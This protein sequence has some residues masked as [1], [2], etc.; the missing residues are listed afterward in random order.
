MAMESQRDAA[1]RPGAGTVQASTLGDVRKAVQ[2]ASRA[3]HHRR[4]VAYAL[5]VHSRTG[6]PALLLPRVR[7]LVRQ[8]LH[9]VYVLNGRLKLERAG[10]VMQVTEEVRDALRS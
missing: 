3:A 6:I 9:Q 2:G 5:G 8:A 4:H 1:S 10:H 7:I